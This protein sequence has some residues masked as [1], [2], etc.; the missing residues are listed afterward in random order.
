MKVREVEKKGAFLTLQVDGK[1]RQ[2]FVK[3]EKKE[4]SSFSSSLVNAGDCV[5]YT[6]I[7]REIVGE[8]YDTYGSQILTGYEKFE[9]FKGWAGLEYV[10]DFK[11]LE[12]PAKKGKLK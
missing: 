4:Y 12:E 10:E 11:E 3:E 1:T 8:R 7:L 2:F 6:A 5:S 9:Y